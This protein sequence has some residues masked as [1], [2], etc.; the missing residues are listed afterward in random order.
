MAEVGA[1]PLLSVSEVKEDTPGVV[2]T[3]KMCIQDECAWW[4]YHKGICVV[5]VKK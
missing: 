3:K 5:K 1:C 2:V 4:D